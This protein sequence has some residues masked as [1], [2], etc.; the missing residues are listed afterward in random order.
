MICWRFDMSQK[1]KS[2]EEWKPRE[3]MFVERNI[4]DTRQL[5]KSKDGNWIVCGNGLIRRAMQDGCE[6]RYT[7]EEL[8]NSDWK[9]VD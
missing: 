8:L 3:K 6:K 5:Y 7:E 9:P 2:E 1:P 4:V